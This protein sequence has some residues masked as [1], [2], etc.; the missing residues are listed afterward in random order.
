M[1]NYTIFFIVLKSI[2]TTAKIWCKA[3]MRQTM[4][5]ATHNLIVLEIED[6]YTVSNGVFIENIMIAL[7]CLGVS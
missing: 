6:I 4:S 1:G 5:V 2:G 7:I 3:V